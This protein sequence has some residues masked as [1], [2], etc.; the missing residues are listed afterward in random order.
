MKARVGYV[1]T[2]VHHL[3]YQTYDNV[4]NPLTGQRPLPAFNMVTAVQYEGVSSF[5]GMVAELKRKTRS[6]LFLDFN[7]M[8]SH[9]LND[10][11]GGGGGPQYPQNVSCRSCDQAN[12]QFDA[13]QSL[14]GSAT[15]SL[16]FGRK[17]RL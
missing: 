6:G 9:A 5:N 7:H 2:E 12:S 16:P 13:R 14:H 15:Y 17:S 11:S 10:G 3:F 8:W 4:I 1:G